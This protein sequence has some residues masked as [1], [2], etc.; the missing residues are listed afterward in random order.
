MFFKN[1]LSSKAVFNVCIQIIP[2]TVSLISIPVAIDN[3]GKP[4]WYFFTL[5]LTVILLP[6]YFTFG[7]GPY[8]IRDLSTKVNFMESTSWTGSISLIKIMGLCFFILTNFYFYFSDIEKPFLHKID[9]FLFFLFFLLSSLVYFFLI[10]LRS[11]IESK[12]DFYFLGTL[13][14]VFTSLLMLVP[15]FSYNSIW[16][17]SFI[18]FIMS[19]FQLF[20]YLLRL[21]YKH[22]QQ[23]KYLFTGFSIIDMK[24]T[25]LKIWPFG[26]YLIIWSILLYSDRFIFK[27]FINTEIL[28][29]HVTMQDLFN[30]L[31]I[32]S[33]NVTAVFYPVISK[34]KGNKLF[35][36]NYYKKQIRLISVSFISL[37][38]ILLFG[39]KPFLSFWLKN[40]YSFYIDD[41]S[42]LYLIGIMLFNFSIIQVRTLQAIG[43]E[44]YVLKILI[45]I[46]IFYFINVFIIGYYEKP[47][48]LSIMLIIYSL[49][50]IFKFHLKYVKQKT[51]HI[52]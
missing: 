50:I 3:L 35:V 29:D 22:S 51:I 19:L 45:L 33:G 6:N 26:G 49:I 46:S 40:K 38:L 21:K 39:L 27:F 30:R 11:I 13:R 17:F 8:L 42:F 31:A 48:L 20:I 34:N 37:L 47:Y 2:I 5:G 15:I 4:L 18:I 12:Q 23:I 16:F 9:Q 43:Y 44:V 28:S 24:N 7:I 52:I 32:I 1:K 10:P 14:S 25:I 36:D 41:F